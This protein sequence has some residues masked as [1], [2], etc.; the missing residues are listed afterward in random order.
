[1]ITVPTRPIF[2][3][4]QRLTADQLNQAL[5]FLRDAIR[6]LA[7]GALGAGVGT[8]LGLEL[9]ANQ[10][11]LSIESGIAIDGKGRLLVLQTDRRVTLADI[12]KQTGA[13]QRQSS[14]RVRLVLDQNPPNPLDPCAPNRDQNIIENVRLTFERDE[15]VPAVTS[16]LALLTSAPRHCV[17]PEGDL[18]QTPPS[19]AGC[20]VTLG[21]LSRDAEGRLIVSH[22]LRDGI[23]PQFGVIRGPTGVASIVLGDLGL[24]VSPNSTTAE[25]SIA[26]V[27]FGRFTVGLSGAFGFFDFGGGTDFQATQVGPDSRDFATARMWPGSERVL[28]LDGGIPALDPG[29]AAPRIGGLLTVTAQLPPD[30]VDLPR[31][32]IALEFDPA[33]SGVATVRRATD[34]TNVMGLSA[35]PSSSVPGSQGHARQVPVA[36]AG[37][38]R[39]KVQTSFTLPAGTDLTMGTS[40]EFLRAAESNDRVVG[41][42]AEKITVSGSGV[43]T[44]SVIIFI[45]NAA[46]QSH[47]PGT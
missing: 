17:P 18:D 23:G 5:D 6:R 45:V 32:G 41:R 43:Q 22:A 21:H 33:N 28:A 46:V 34:R 40:A 19:D 25:S 10:Q 14:I 35:A 26:F 3:N 11:A 42:L 44:F 7:T 1:M 39:A 4:G 8:G 12:E 30:A 20:G 13:I 31:Q 37:F 9:A 24:K 16:E 27:H 29:D 36:L 15:F 38:M 2:Q 47:V